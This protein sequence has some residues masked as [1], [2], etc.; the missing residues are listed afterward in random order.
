MLNNIYEHRCE[1]KIMQ[2]NIQINWARLLFYNF[3]KLILT[4]Y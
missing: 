3:T 2:N 1:N 4:Y